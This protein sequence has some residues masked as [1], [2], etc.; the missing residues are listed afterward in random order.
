MDTRD[1]GRVDLSIE[2]GQLKQQEFDRVV[3]A[4]VLRRF[5]EGVRAV[6]G[7]GGDEGIDIEIMKGTRRTILQLKCFPEGFSGGFKATRRQQIKDSFTTAMKKRKPAEWTLVLPCV[8]T[9]EEDKFVRELRG[10][11]R[12][13]IKIVD[14]D[15]LDSWLADDPDLDAYFQRTPI[16]VLM[17]YAQVFNRETAALLNGYED[18]QQRI[19]ALASV[20]RTVDPRFSYGFATE[21]RAS[22]ITVRP[23]KGIPLPDDAGFYVTLKPGLNT[24]QAAHLA[25]LEEDIGYG[26]AE[27]MRIPSD[28]IEW[29]GIKGPALFDGQ[30]LPPG[31]V[32]IR[33]GTSPPHAGQT[34]ELRLTGFGG[35]MG[36][37]GKTYSYE[38]EVAH[39]DGGPLGYSLDL[40]LCQGQLKVQ[41][42]LPRTQ[43]DDEQFGDVSVRLGYK[44]PKARPGVVAELLGVAR[45]IRSA[46]VLELY[47][48]DVRVAKMAGSQPISV[49]EY[50][51]DEL[52]IEQFAYDL[53]ILQTRCK[54]YFNLP[55]SISPRDRIDVRVARIL[56]DGGIIASPTARTFTAIM[57]GEDTPGVRNA[58]QNPWMVAIQAAEP[59]A[60]TIDGRTLT[61]GDVYVIHP[62][63]TAL[64][65]DDALD[66]LDAGDAE[67]FAVR[68]R[69][70]DDHY[71]LLAL[72]DKP[73]SDY[74]GKPVSLWGLVDIDQ[75]D[76]DKWLE[77]SA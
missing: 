9:N 8:C 31:D 66:A 20:I 56:L 72:A 60:V 47:A 59:Y 45:H 1:L 28:M 22:R 43:P 49:E 39:F 23:I 57:T 33:L 35:D 74:F 12:V 41:F 24:E 15:E 65:G 30:R 5:R 7:R 11:S 75:P 61:I 16:N 4:L 10:T 40:L 69:P 36:E 27:P 32:E 34:I 17:Q 67:S 29:V 6:D 25:A 52:I 76:A 64:N 3:E 62:R 55:E 37:E 2:W 73:V 44:L 63:A 58:L 18:V 77:G 13:K 19:S 26:S 50:G 71:F 51:T 68:L 14:R 48:R 21:G 42:K 54:K 46:A 70:G 53:D 38:G